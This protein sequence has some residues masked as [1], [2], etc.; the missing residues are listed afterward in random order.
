MPDYAEACAVVV[1]AARQGRALARFLARRGARVILTDARPE[2]EMMDTLERMADVPNLEWALGGHP[3]SLLDVATVVCPSG[4]VPLTIPF[5]QAARAR[6]LHFSNDSQVFLDESPCRVVGITGSAGKTTTTTLLGRMA[7]AAEGRGLRRA[8]VGGNIGTPLLEML[9]D[10]TAADLAVMELSSF[11]LELMT[12]SPQVAGILNITPN[13]LDRH[14]T[15]AAYTAAKLNILTHQ[16][17]EDT[18]VL[19]RDDPA[20]WGLRE[21]VRGQWLGFGLEDD[22]Q[23]GAFVRGEQAWLRTDAGERAVLPVSDILL[24]GLHNV[25]NVLAACA[26]GAAAGL[27]DDALRAG[28]QGF[29]GVPHRLELVRAWGGADWINDSKATTPSAV[30]MALQSIR[31]PIVLLMGGRDKALPWQEFAREVAASNVVRV[32]CFGEAAGLIRAALDEARVQVAVE[33]VPGLQAAVA[34][35]TVAPPAGGV[36]LLSP[37]CTSFDEFADYEQRGDRFK[38]WVQALPA[39]SEEQI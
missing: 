31:R 23:P 12:T 26:L 22:G 27:P 20:A 35:A 36:V 8:W 37:G 19:G 13:H 16:T 30:I 4:G 15:L 17:A 2:A 28:V 24:P 14:G 11:Q 29:R 7:A 18:A 39:S 21:Q 25:R 6:G 38:E 1:G 33:S 10:M 32:I 5:L 9:D 3:E 34:A